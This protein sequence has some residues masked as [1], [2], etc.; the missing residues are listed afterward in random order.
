[1]RITIM[2]TWLEQKNAFAQPWRYLAEAAEALAQGG[3]QVWF[4][5]DD[6][7]SGNTEIEFAGFPVERVPSLRGR[8]LATNEQ[9]L[10]VLD[11]QHPDLVLWHMGLTSFLQTS[12]LRRISIPVVGLFTSPVYRPLELLRL[13][14][15]PLISDWH[16]SRTH[17]LG[18]LVPSAAI[19][20]ALQSGRPSKLVVECETTRAA[21]L[22]QGAPPDAVQVIKPCIGASWLQAN[23]T[24]SV[25]PEIR[26]Q[27][28]FN[29]DDFVV[30]YVGAPAPLRGLP[31]LAKALKQAIQHIPRLRL[32]VLARV[33]NEID[34]FDYDRI[35]AMIDR[36]NL[37]QH[38]RILPGV[39]SP[40]QLKNCLA[41][42]DAAALPFLLV[43]S[44]VPVSILEVMSMG[45]P[46]I[47]TDVACIPE[48]VPGG[49]GIRVPP[50]QVRA[51]AGALVT[52]AQDAALAASLAQVGRQHALQ[53]CPSD[54]NLALWN[55]LVDETR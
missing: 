20:R 10:R 22:R 5:S 48:M 28:G 1:M 6:C 40:E 51:L 14:P 50:G 23:S 15:A 11:E 37:E 33:L 17:L 49:A 41:A 4:L 43:P 38:V 53:W 34:Q 12:I 25:R 36:N 29:V 26:A 31:L 46:L 44:D 30:G 54:A 2:S 9:L 39:L 3:H 13:G 19:R 24:S 32:L 47:T 21:L 7:P 8:L 35:M 52:L 55:R 18:Q 42:C 45:L 16:L 27:L